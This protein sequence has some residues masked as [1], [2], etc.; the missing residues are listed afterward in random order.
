MYCHWVGCHWSEMCME[1]GSHYVLIHSLLPCQIS[2]GTSWK[3][4]VVMLMWCCSEFCCSRQ[5]L[6]ER[7]TTW[8]TCSRN[9]SRPI[10]CL[11]FRRCSQRSCCGCVAVSLQKAS[12]GI[13]NT[14][15]QTRWHACNRFNDDHCKV[16]LCQP[17]PIVKHYRTF[18]STWKAAHFLRIPPPP[19]TS[20]IP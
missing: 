12:S 8:W 10:S 20:R 13:I 18:R 6:V 9:I 4:A 15:T 19:Y 2:T 3:Q 16:N 11:G 7:W 5:C 14:H 17:S 1:A